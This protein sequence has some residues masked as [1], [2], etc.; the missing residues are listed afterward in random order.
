MP[1]PNKP[2]KTSRVRPGRYQ[3]LGIT[4]KPGEWCEI[5]CVVVDG[6]SDAAGADLP[7]SVY[8]SAAMATAEAFHQVWKE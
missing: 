5:E 3:R 8:P 4:K 2:R 7:L 6:V 1:D